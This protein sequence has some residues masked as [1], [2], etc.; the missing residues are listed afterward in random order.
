MKVAVS[1]AGGMLG[2]EVCSVLERDHAVTALG[3]DELDITGGADQ[4]AS[5][6]AL[7]APD[8]LINCAAYTDVDGCEF[9]AA[10]AYAVNAE[11]VKNLAL[12]CR[13][14]GVKLVHISTD[15]VFDGASGSPYAEDSTPNPLSV[16]GR[17]KLAGELHIRE[18]LQSWLII[19]TEWLYGRSGRNFVGTMLR[20]SRERDEL[21]VVNDQTGSPTCAADL[22]RAIAALLSVSA[23]GIYHVTNSGSCTWYDFACRILSLSGLSTR[24]LPISTGR[25][26]RPAARPAH[27]VLDCSKFV[28]ATGQAM[29]PWEEALAEYLRDERSW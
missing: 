24:V 19:R 12:A 23:T 11:G 27:S 17:S 2:H 16:Y 8:V 28:R 22:A 18:A 10:R 9:D 1:G 5:A 13:R 25:L 21:E 15:Y 29:R 26:A 7:L 4:A 20:L 3:H 6:L 14:T